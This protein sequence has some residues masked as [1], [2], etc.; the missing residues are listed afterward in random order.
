MFRA[1]IFLAIFPLLLFASPNPVGAEAAPG[2]AITTS[3]GP[4]QFAQCGLAKRVKCVVDGDTFWHRG[5]KIRISDIN[6][7]E[8]S[9]PGCDDEARL[10][11]HATLHLTQLLNA[12]PFSLERQGRDV[13]RYGRQLRTVTRRGQS[14]GAVLVAEGLAENWTDRRRDWCT[15]VS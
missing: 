14:L 7:P 5:T 10:G 15:A 12:G 6:T 9:R 4:V 2:V 1:S 8:T 3:A 11:A 13:D